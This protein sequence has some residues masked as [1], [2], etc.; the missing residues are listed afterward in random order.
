MIEIYGNKKNQEFLKKNLE[1][2][3]FSHAYLFSG[4]RH[5]GKKTLAKQFAE[6]IL[7]S[8]NINSHPDAMILESGQDDMIKKVREIK[9][10]ICL[11]P[12]RASRKVVLCYDIDRLRLDAL[13]TFLKSLEEPLPDVIFILTASRKI[14]AT[15]ESRCVVLKFF[16]LSNNFMQDVVKQNGISPDL[17]GMV[18]NFS[19]GRPGLAYNFNSELVDKSLSYLLNTDIGELLDFAT[20]LSPKKVKPAPAN[21]V[22]NAVKK[23]SFAPAGAMA[24]ETGAVAKIQFLLYNWIGE[25]RE[26]MLSE[27]FSD[28]TKTVNLLKELLKAYEMIEI[29]GANVKL[30]LENLFLTFNMS[31]K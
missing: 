13:N 17:T 25:A 16:P 28:K 31:T 3:V 11:S 6:S 10:K 7:C 26:L 1:D 4:A 8:D 19:M 29:T 14:L 20:K 15:V 27:N 24:D 5:L 9:K 18:L 12:Q 21:S 23:S 30:I 2:G 22:K